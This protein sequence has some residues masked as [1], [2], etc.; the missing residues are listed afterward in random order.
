MKTVFFYIMANMLVFFAQAQNCPYYSLYI[1]KGDKI[2]AMPNPKFDDAISAYTAALLHCP[3]MAS[4]AEE[5]INSVF[6]KIQALKN[7]AEESEKKI[8]E[9]RNLLQAFYDEKSKEQDTQPE[10]E[11]SEW[12][13]YVIEEGETL[14]GIAKKFNMNVKELRQANQLKS[15]AI[16][17][18]DT[19]RIRVTESAKNTNN[20]NA[21][22]VVATTNLNVNIPPSTFGIV[23]SVDTN[24]AGADF[25]VKKMQKLLKNY[26]V[27]VKEENTKFY[28]IIQ[29][30]SKN[31]N[32]LLKEVLLLTKRPVW[33][34]RF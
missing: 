17:V 3:E 2:I 10:K 27:E 9:I 29:V 28:T 22:T 19:L 18:L 21:A 13:E 6:A 32:K 12:Q 33:L 16:R 31:Q 11:I 5:K 1:N 34:K 23:L 7:R 8:K 4:E 25:E 14:F 30:S 26:K 24:K 20:R 15:D